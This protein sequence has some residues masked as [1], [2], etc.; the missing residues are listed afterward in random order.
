MLLEVNELNLFSNFAEIG[1]ITVKIN[2]PKIKI[3]KAIGLYISNIDNPTFLIDINSLLDIK[4]LNRKAI[5]I[6]I[7]NE[8][9]CEIIEG[10]LSNDNNKKVVKLVSWWAI[11]RDISNKF[12]NEN[13]IAIINI[14]N[15]INFVDIKNMYK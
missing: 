5:E 7:T 4:F 2:N 11:K 14:L 8:I 10:I 1:L 9:V 6:I 12:I 13:N 15:K 3:E